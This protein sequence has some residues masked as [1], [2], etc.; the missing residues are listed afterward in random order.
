MA[1]NLPE[2][3]EPIGAYAAVVIRRRIGVVSGQFPIVDGRLAWHGRLGVELDLET[4][5]AAA[6]AAAMNALA[7]IARA[8]DGFARL[9][10]LLRLEGHVASAEG[11]A[12]Q[13]AV[14][15]AA[16]ELFAECLGA[17][18]HH[19]RTAHAPPRLPLN[20][21]VELVVSFTAKGAET[22]ASV[23]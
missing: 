21:P 3:P 18:G 5:R 10:G 22:E 7:H 9:E 13:P 23:W 20:A 15:D 19:A 17:A 2:P 14:L 12:H 8:T 11:F 6:R 4:G 1:G 16:S